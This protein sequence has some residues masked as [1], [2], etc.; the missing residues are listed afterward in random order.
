MVFKLKTIFPLKSK[1]EDNGKFQ[2][3]KLVEV[4]GCCLDPAPD[5]IATASVIQ[6]RSTEG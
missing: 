6:L 2:G 1:Y 3:N 4:G 5:P